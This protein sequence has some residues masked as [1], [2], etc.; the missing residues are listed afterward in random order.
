MN[1]GLIRAKTALL[2]LF[3]RH[4]KKITALFSALILGGG[5]GA[6]AVASL[7]PET[8]D[9]PVRTVLEAVEPLPLQWQVDALERQAISLYRTETTRSSDSFESLLKRLGINDPKAAAYMRSSAEARSTLLG[10]AGRNVTAEATVGNKLLKLSVRWNPEDDGSFKRLVIESHTHGFTSR[11][12][13]AALTTS[14]RIASGTIRSTLFAA[15]DDAHIPDTVATQLAEIFAGD[16]D[17]HRAL[18]KGDRFS[19]V[20]ETMEADGE[21]LRAGR[22]LSAEFTNNGKTFQAMWFQESGTAKGAYYDPNGESLRRAYLASPLTFSRVTSG[23]SMRLHP[24]LNTW[25]AH[26]GVDYA[27]PTGTAVRTVANGEVDFAGVQN[28]FGNVVIIKHRN[29][30]STVYA[31]LSHIAVRRGE[32]VT[33]GQN[34]GNVGATGWAT[35]PH[36][37]FEFRVNGVH[38]DPLTLARQSDSIPVTAAAKAAFAVAASTMRKELGAAATLQQ[39]NAQ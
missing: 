31:H 3:Q 23:F 34:I 16:I 5:G 22:V 1:T 28:G 12:E 6:F 27:A 38:Q 26:L 39:A 20:Y 36:L 37:H 8:V 11:V 24:I 35:G 14:N 17:F 21:L 4:P 30:H 13:S 29:N 15:T 2:S 10:R 9:Q 18:R 25:K 33:Q 19:V 7:V 32:Q